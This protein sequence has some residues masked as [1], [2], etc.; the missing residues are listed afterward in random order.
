MGENI[1]PTW[2]CCSASLDLDETQLGDRLE[3][4]RHHYAKLV[5]YPLAIRCERGRHAAVAT[6]GDSEPFCRW[7]HFAG[8][9]RLA[10]ATAYTPTGWERIAGK[11]PL[12]EAPLALASGVLAD[13][14]DASRKLNAPIALAVLDGREDRL[15]VV[16]DALGAARVYEAESG[17]VRA[18]SNRPGALILFLGLEAKAD[19]RAWMVLAGASWFLGDTAPIEGVR[20]LPGGT[21]IEARPDGID[22]RS[23]RAAGQWVTSSESLPE[24]AEIAIDHARAQARTGAQLWPGEAKVDL[25]GGR[26]SRL[27]AAAIIA[28]D[29]PARFLTSDATPGEAD[30]ARALI[31]A[32]PGDLDHEVSRTEAG[33]ATPSTE[34][35]ERARNLHLLHDGVRHPQKL[36]GKMTLPRPRPRNATFS[37]HGGEIAHGFFYKNE[38]QLKKVA[39]R[40]KRIPDR[41]MRFFEK[42][43]GAARPEAYE[44]ALELVEENFDAGR[45]A[46]LDGPVLLDW[47]YLTE[48][49]AHRSGLATDSERISVFATPG[50]VGA[51]FAL[52]PKD[53]LSDR[54][55][56]DLIGRL[57]PEWRDLPFF[58]EPATNMPSNRRDRLWE[59]D[60]DAEVVEEILAGGGPW[61]EIYDPTKAKDAWRELRAGGGSAKWEGIFEGIVYRHTFDDHLLRLNEAARG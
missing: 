42:D 17:G 49:F 58:E 43:H 38:R 4:V 18:W 34:L 47:F 46:G 55:H 51:S 25:S 36:R 56:L 6:I 2:I 24:L 35:L 41:V 45:E 40:K 3:R 19:T 28:A 54:L 21:V 1:D 27:V 48:R 13:P 14:G 8:D 60:R 5:D 50:F 16:N 61:T 57:V 12:N 52:E 30:I 23:T 9:A 29:A 44:M 11:K 33:S 26:D 37:G 39:R 53:R 15:V 22:E 31:E 10:I 7:P 20:R 32:A 59:I